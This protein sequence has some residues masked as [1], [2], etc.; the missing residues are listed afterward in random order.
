MASIYDK[1]DT[2]PDNP[3]YSKRFGALAYVSP[4]NSWPTVDSIAKNY[5][6]GLSRSQDNPNTYQ[7]TYNRTG[8]TL[9]NVTT[10]HSGGKINPQTADTILD[11][12]EYLDRVDPNYQQYDLQAQAQAASPLTQALNL[13]APG[14]FTKKPT[15]LAKTPYGNAF[16][17]ALNKV[18]GA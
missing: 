2:S 3:F 14:E 6:L 17:E 12:A 9:G 4:L 7:F 16:Q 11:Y 15:P 18:Y 10:T 5:N 13:I 8:R 1:L